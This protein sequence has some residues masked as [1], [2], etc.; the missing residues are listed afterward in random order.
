MTERC[1]VCGGPVRIASGGEGTNSYE[2]PK[3]DVSDI[4]ERLEHGVVPAASF[5][6]ALARAEK[7]EAEVARLREAIRELLTAVSAGESLGWTWMGGGQYL[8]SDEPGWDLPSK[9][10]A[11]HARLAAL[12]DMSVTAT[13][14]P[15]RA[16]E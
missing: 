6:F 15:V 1:P 12:A 16:Q 7:A 4:E 2:R 10:Q 9:M 8:S 14:E 11:A 5:V 3:C 13:S